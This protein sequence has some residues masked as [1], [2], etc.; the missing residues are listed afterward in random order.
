M[1][2]NTQTL[3]NRLLFFDNLRTLMVLL[4]LVFHSA[5]SYGAMIAFWPYHDPNPTELVDLTMLLLDVFMMSVLFFIAGYF[6]LPSLQKK[7]GRGFVTDKLKR[8][9]I[10]WLVVTI[11]VL[12]AL[13]YVHYYTRSTGAGIP[14]RSYGAHWWLGMQKI[15]EF[16]TGRLRM[17][18]YLDV[19][20]QF[21][22]RYM[23]FLSLLLLF[24]LVFWLLYAAREM[25]RRTRG[26]PS[27]Q[28]TAADGSVYPALAVAGL[29]NVVLFALVRFLLSS[30]GNPFDM[31]WCSLG[32]LVQFEAAKLAFYAP[33]FGLGV[34]A[35]SRKW[36]TGG[37]DLGRPW[38]WGLA[39]FLLLIVNMLVGRGITRTA[40]PSL[41][42]Q[43]AL[44]VL[45]PL[46]TFS[47]LGAFTAFASRHWNRATP[48]EKELAANSYNMYLVHNVFAMTLPLLLSTWM[49]GP[50]LIEFG[51]VAL[52]TLLL[53]YAASRYVIGPFPRL[54][55]IGLAGVNAL[56]FLVT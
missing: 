41:A 13:D 8:L 5:A 12:P 29:L 1:K 53:S 17:S 16:Y 46:W 33:Y 44:A 23:W 32:N 27:G 24:F 22:Q 39:C 26:S 43:V 25:W 30:P 9:G 3:P 18:R 50:V 15:A 6:A 42:L 34:Y 35:C 51:I 56:L 37:R 10:P 36:F 7:G 14:P 11:L 19:T 45:Y 38:P 28:K 21:Y 47:F 4:V 54:V 55:V 2:K 20:E 40:E 31:V 52:A 48:L 49:E